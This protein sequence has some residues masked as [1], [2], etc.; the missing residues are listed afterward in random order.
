MIQLGP[1]EITT[2]AP[3][4]ILGPIEI[5][6]ASDAVDPIEYMSDQLSTDRQNIVIYKARGNRFGVI[7]SHEGE[8]LDLSLFTRF[9]LY[10]LT[11]SPINSDTSQTAFDWDNGSGEIVFDIG[12]LITASGPTKTTL[13]GYSASNPDGIVLWHK[14]MAASQ[15]TINVINA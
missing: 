1:V 9:E 10:G 2:V 11:E 13:I 8:A 15:L 5:T 3:G 6:T 7:I 14:D 4:L 12:Q